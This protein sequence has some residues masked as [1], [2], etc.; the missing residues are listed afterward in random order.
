MVANQSR[1]LLPQYR[2]G[3]TKGTAG[4]STVLNNLIGVDLNKL[5]R[6]SLE[7]V[8]RMSATADAM[9]E[10]VDFAK[11]A[12]KKIQQILKDY[13]TIEEIRAEVAKAGLARYAAINEVIGDITKET[14]QAQINERLLQQKISNA[15]QL[16]AANASASAAIEEKSLANRLL[17]LRK[18]TDLT[19]NQMHRATQQEIGQEKQR[20][21]A[22]EKTKAARRQYYKTMNAAMDGHIPASRARGMLAGLKKAL[23]SNW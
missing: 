1:P 17:K 14:N 15:M 8:Q 20:I 13:Q 11:K 2:V 21:I 16:Q 18:G 3:K 23:V 9:K 6:M 19:I 5:G 10:Q 7:D 22:S 4:A 12:A